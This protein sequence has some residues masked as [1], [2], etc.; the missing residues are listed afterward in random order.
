MNTNVSSNQ[1]FLNRIIFKSTLQLLVSDPLFGVKL[2][3]LTSLKLRA[4]GTKCF[5]LGHT[6]IWLG[7]LISLCDQSTKF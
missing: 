2:K 3:A 5:K 1:K 7:V 4:N 6:R